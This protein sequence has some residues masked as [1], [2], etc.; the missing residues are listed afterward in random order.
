T[1]Q[2]RRRASR[3]ARTKEHMT[4]Q[5]WPTA[6]TSSTYAGVNVRPV[7][8]RAFRRGLVRLSHNIRFESAPGRSKPVGVGRS[9]LNGSRSTREAGDRVSPVPRPGVAT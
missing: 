9:E 8:G 7:V 2:V 3:A 4:P 5:V 6:P 1:P